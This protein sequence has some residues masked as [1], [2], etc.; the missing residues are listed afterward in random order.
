M[1]RENLPQ[2]IT[3]VVAG[4]T[5]T[6]VVSMQGEFISIGI[7]PSDSQAKYNIDITDNGGFGICGG[8]NLVGITTMPCNGHGGYRGWS[9]KLQ[10]IR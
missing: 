2:L 3:I 4:G 7:K 6:I 10:R 9:W 5:G 8:S 1:Y